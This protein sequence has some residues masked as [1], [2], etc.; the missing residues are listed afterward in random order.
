MSRADVMSSWDSARIVERIRSIVEA[1][2]RKDMAAFMPIGYEPDITP[3]F[4]EWLS[5]ENH[6]LYLPVYEQEREAYGLAEITETSSQLSIGHH[7]IPEPLPSL[8]RRFP[9]FTSDVSLLWLVPGLAF[10]R[11]GARLG[12][13]AGYYD[14]LLE[15]E[16]GPKLGIGHDIQLVENL[17]SCPHDVRMD[18]VITESQCV[19]CV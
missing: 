3:L 17:P 13:G 15:G 10:D 16:S 8:P 7:G 2:G 4:A 9:P 5:K 19:S 18:Y 12:R 6:R 14:R 11:N 1:S